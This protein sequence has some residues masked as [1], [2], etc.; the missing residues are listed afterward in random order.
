[1][2]ENKGSFGTKIENIRISN[3]EISNAEISNANYFFVKCSV[4]LFT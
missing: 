4:L 1:M 3:I 2:K